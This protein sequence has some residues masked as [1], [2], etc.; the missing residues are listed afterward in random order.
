MFLTTLLCIFGVLINLYKQVISSKSRDKDKARVEYI[1]NI[2][3]LGLIILALAAFLVTL[4]HSFIYGATYTGAKP[5]LLFAVL[6]FLLF[7]L[8]LS[9]KGKGDIS[10]RIFVILIFTLTLYTSYKWGSDSSQAL[11]MYSLIIVIAGI[12]LGSPSAFVV[13][14]ISGFIIILLAYLENNGVHHP[15]YSWK[16]RTVRM[17]GAIVFA[18]TLAVTAIVSWLFNREMERALKRARSSELAL[19]K[20]KDELEVIVEKRTKQLRQAQAEKI[21]QL[22]RF[23]QLGRSASGLFHDLATPLTLVSLNLKRLSKS[24]DLHKKELSDFRVAW[25]RAVGGTRKLE[26][27]I[28]A[29][30]K[31][32]QNQQSLKWFSLE[33]EINQAIQMLEHRAKENHIKIVFDSSSVTKIYGNSLKFNQLMTNLISNSIDA[34][35]KVRKRS[36]V[37][38]IRFEKLNRYILLEIQD[39]GSGISRKNLPKIFDPLF[40]TK[41]AE[42][43]TGIGLSICKDIIEKDFTG[44]Y[45]IDSKI[46]VGTTFTIEFPIK[47]SYKS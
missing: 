28:T 30:R 25:E 24:R 17:G 9:K 44:K 21:E 14:L 2:L 38:E 26:E 5:I 4:S 45:T 37:I 35:D 39:W 7:L 41:G 33:D 1:L 18:V 22:Y 31:Q 6:L 42:K 11:L 32:I 29:A 8:L 36:K 43:G 27:F 15:D 47:K 16:L 10:A 23:A 3:L 19:R 12:L 20:Q 40:T 13:T 34:Y 46:G